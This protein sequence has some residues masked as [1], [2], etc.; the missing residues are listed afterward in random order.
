MF[1]AV[2]STQARAGNIFQSKE[3]ERSETLVA[4]DPSS[5]FMFTVEREVET[6][7]SLAN[8]SCRSETGYPNVN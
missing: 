8:W 5:P 4:P 3:N 6:P 7:V 1:S 2:A